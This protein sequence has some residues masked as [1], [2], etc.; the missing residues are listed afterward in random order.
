MIPKCSYPQYPVHKFIHLVPKWPYHVHNWSHLV[1]K[2]TYPAHKCSHL[3]LNWLYPSGPRIL[4]PIPI[5]LPFW[6]QMEILMGSIGAILR[7]YLFIYGHD[8][9]TLGSDGSIYGQCRT[10]LGPDQWIYGQDMAIL[11]PEVSIYSQDSTRFGSRCSIYWQD[12]VILVQMG[13]FMDR[14]Y[15]NKAILEPDGSII[16]SL[17]ICYGYFG[18]INGRNMAIFGPDG[19]IYSPMRN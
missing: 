6:D 17:W 3:F 19:S 5:I 1:S 9:Y 8:R 2:C 7:W 11:G 15:Y 4:L 16:P 18:T 10:I 13:V 12:R 14:L